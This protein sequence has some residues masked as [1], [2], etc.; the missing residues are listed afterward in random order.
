LQ[1]PASA[2]PTGPSAPAATPPTGA[3]PNSNKFKG[4][5][6]ALKK[7]IENN[8]GSYPHPQESSTPNEV[9]QTMLK[10]MLS[11]GQGAQFAKTYFKPQY[12]EGLKAHLGDDTYAKFV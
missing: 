6:N 12:Q 2:S 7:H 5:A 10:G 3:I 1:P 4:P 9:G 8:A 11:Q